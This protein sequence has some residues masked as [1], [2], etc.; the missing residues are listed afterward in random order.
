MP[1][2]TDILGEEKRPGSTTFDPQLFKSIYIFTQLLTT[3]TLSLSSDSYDFLSTKMTKI[4]FYSWKIEQ[5]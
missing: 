5:Q 4:K 2:I 1:G 3:F